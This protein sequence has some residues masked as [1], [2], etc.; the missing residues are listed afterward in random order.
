MLSAMPY[1]PQFHHR[2]SIRWKGYDYSSRGLY[3]VTICSKN[4]EQF[5]AR[6]EDGDSIRTPEGEIAHST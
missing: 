6:I 4:R 5:L 3:F 2:R 1:D